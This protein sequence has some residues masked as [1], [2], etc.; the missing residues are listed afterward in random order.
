MA[1]AV[2]Y[3]AR[4]RIADIILDDGKVNAMALPFFDAL[5]AAL[6]R[7]ESERPG[8]LVITGRPGVFSAGLNLKLLPTLPAAELRRTMVAFGRVMLRVFT[9]PVPTVAA[10]SGHAIAG[11]AML[12]FA[13]D[14][15]IAAD[16]AFR[17][18]LN[19][20][21]IGLTLP[22]WAIVLA[23]SAVPTR[24]HAEAILHARAYSPRDALERGIVDAVA[25]PDRLLDDAHALAEP[26]A[27]LDAVAYAG[28]KRRHR[29]MA[30]E[31]ATAR[32][33][34]ELVELPA[35]P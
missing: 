7:A 32:L 25:A 18:H 14:L 9:F 27:A 5:N 26:L 35:R 21:A 24:W 6:D 12:G 11:G 19:E 23:Q 22:T 10:L 16:G 4:D 13:C 30:V 34:S 1:E 20:V 3:V 2:T 33:E 28:S 31:W 29:A 17:L 8:A 15:R